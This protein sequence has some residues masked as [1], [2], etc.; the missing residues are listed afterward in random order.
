MK[1]AKC[2]IVLILGLASATGGVSTTK[3][4]LQQER[5]EVSV[6]LRVVNLRGLVVDPHNDPVAGSHVQ[7][8]KNIKNRV[9]GKS[10]WEQGPEVS[11]T[12]AN[13]RGAFLFRRIP[14]GRYR[15]LFSMNGFDQMYYSNIVVNPKGR[16]G[17]LHI[18]MKLAT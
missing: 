9:N 1:F 5:I 6:R 12:R 10:V 14:A 17:W 2:A 18:E 3:S 13:D 15:V 4:N 11:S 7:V 8:F 16:H